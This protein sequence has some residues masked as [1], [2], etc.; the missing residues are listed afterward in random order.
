MKRLFL[1]IFLVFLAVLPVF[2][3]TPEFW[4]NQMNSIGIA[5]LVV[6]GLV[7]LTGVGGLTSFGQ[8]AFVGIG[9][10][11][12]AYL[13]TSAGYSPWLGLV[14]AIALTFFVSYILGQITLRLSGHYLPLATIAVCLV[15]YYLYG[16]MGFLGRHDGIPGIPPIEIFGFS[17]LKAKHVYYL[18]WVLV[19]FAVW[20]SKN[21]L[22]SRP[23]RA[24]R[25]LKSGAG[26][27]ESFGVHTQYYKVVAFVYAGVLAGLAGWLYAHEQRAVS[28]STFGINYGIEYLFMAVIGGSASIWGAVFGS[29]LILTMKDKIQDIVPAL[30]NTTANFEMVVFGILMVLIL[31]HAREGLWPILVNFFSRI[32]GR[33]LAPVREVPQAASALPQRAKPGHGQ[34]ILEVNDIRKEF[35]G[36]VAVNDISFS[37]KAGEIMGLIG[38]NGAGK[39]TSFNLITGV[40]S[41]T[42]GSVRFMGQEIGSLSSRKIAALGVGRTFQHVQLLPTMSVLENVALGTHLRTNT[43]IVQSLLHIERDAEAQMLQEAKKQ[44]ERVGLGDYIH[45]QAGNLSLGQQRIVEIARA[46]A[47]DPTLLLLDEPAAGLRYKE[48]QELAKVLSALRDEGMSILLVEHDMDFVMRLT[49]HLVVMDFGTKIAEGTPEQ[50]QTNPVVLEAYLGGVDDD[51]SIS[52]QKDATA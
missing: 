51:L 26:M 3:A 7:V 33:Q 42:S 29:A 18:I 9:A 40:H 46:L 37:I 35:G 6:L 21:L 47:L 16:N 39:S 32:T 31:H 38:P 4:I 22:D 20:T 41:L 52:V 14:L 13:S 50:V 17:L 15:F 12:T 5:S 19:L 45:E 34:L 2:P 36:L 8:A 25:S 44:L 10:Y 27:A 23:G 48:K 1:A 24:I 28:P 43:G 11:A 30:L 49:N